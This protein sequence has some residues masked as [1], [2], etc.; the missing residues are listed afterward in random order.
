M[1]NLEKPLYFETGALLPY[2]RLEVLSHTVQTVLNAALSDVFINDLTELEFASAIA[3][4]VQRHEITEADAF[5]IQQKFLE[6]KALGYYTYQPIFFYDFK[7]ATDWLSERKIFL[8]TCDAIHL[9]YAARMG[10]VLVTADQIL[11]QAA[12]ELNIECQLLIP[13]TH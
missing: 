4:W 10:A 7:Q 5:A 13:R 3:H 12:N 1:E 11:G 9:A 6:H 8:R 2:Y